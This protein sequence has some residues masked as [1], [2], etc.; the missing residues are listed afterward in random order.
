MAMS[1]AWSTLVECDKR[2]QQYLKQ[3]EGRS[4][5]ASPPDEKRRERLPKNKENNRSSSCRRNYFASGGRT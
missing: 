2:L 4:R 5:G 1:L 3:S